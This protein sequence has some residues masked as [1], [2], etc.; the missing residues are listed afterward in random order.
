MK[1]C[2][3]CLLAKLISEFRCLFLDFKISFL[4][5]MP[6]FLIP[7]LLINATGLQAFLYTAAQ[8]TFIPIGGMA[9]LVVKHTARNQFAA[10]HM[11][12]FSI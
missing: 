6:L 3:F 11:S 10:C 7:A 5:L 4:L 12:V 9:T 1:N 2:Q 8:P